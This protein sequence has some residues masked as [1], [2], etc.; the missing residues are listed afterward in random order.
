MTV[1]CL[2]HKFFIEEF[3]IP[4][5]LLLLQKNM[6]WASAKIDDECLE[7]VPESERARAE[8]INILLNYKSYTY[9]I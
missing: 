9:T 2:C 8:I 7:I 5:N 4:P 1:P 3:L 6:P